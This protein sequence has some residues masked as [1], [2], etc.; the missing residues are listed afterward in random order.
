M[1]ESQLLGALCA[2]GS[3]VLF[4]AGDFSGGCATRRGNQFQVLMLSVL[5]SLV[6]LVVLAVL[7]ADPL[8]SLESAAWATLTG[9]SGAVGMV[10]LYRGLAVG[11]AAVVAPTAGVVGV[12]L[13]VIFSSVTHGLPRPLQLAGFIVG[14]AGI[15]TVARY[16]SPSQRDGSPS[17]G[18]SLAV[19]AGSA[20]GGFFVLSSLIEPGSLFA[21]L[22]VA[23]LAAVALALGGVAVS[24]VP[25]IPE[26]GRWVALLAGA[27]DA[28]ANVLYLAAQ[29]LTRVDTAAVLASL[30]PAVTVLLGAAVFRERVASRQWVGVTACMCAAAMILL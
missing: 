2:V 16:H 1:A 21:S 13:P 14:A 29:R 12:A 11:D 7:S 8:P 27:L 6:V 10:A 30:Y 23:K 25:V 5:G 15:W 20:F 9:I 26:K 28:T 19:L 3:A 24:R 18:L 17:G 22:M 4:G